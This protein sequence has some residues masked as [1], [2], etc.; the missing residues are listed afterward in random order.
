MWS[1]PTSSSDCYI[2]PIAWRG[3]EQM[4]VSAQQ[5]KIHLAVAAWEWGSYFPMEQRLK[6]IRLDAWPSTAA[7]IR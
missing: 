4:G 2:R 5:T 1:R 3:S 7:P 6:G